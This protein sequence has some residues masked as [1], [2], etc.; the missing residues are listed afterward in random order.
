[1]RRGWPLIAVGAAY[2]IAVLVWI[3]SDR[4]VAEESFDKFSAANTSEEGLSLAMKYLAR[5]GGRPV[6]MLTKPP[7]ELLPRNAVV[8]RL[9][10]G[11]EESSLLTFIRQQHEEEEEEDDAPKGK[12]KKEPAKPPAIPLLTAEEEAF[13]SRGGRFVIVIGGKYPPLDVRNVGEAKPAVKVFPLWPGI[14]TISL[15]ERR[16]L[17]GAAV[18]RR[19]HALYV[20]GEQPAMARALIGSGDLIVLAAPELFE[21]EHVARHLDLLAAL[22]G[23]RRPVYFDETVHG[24]VSD[25]GTLELL[26]GWRLGPMLL[27]L[28]VVTAAVL[29]RGARSVGK[30]ADDFRDTRSDAVDLVVSL[31]ALY[32]KTMTN[33]EAL[34]LYHQALTQTVAAQTGARGEAL[35]KRVAA[36]TGGLQLPDKSEPLGS[37]RF[38][39]FLSKL[40]DAFRRLE[41]AEHR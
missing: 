12:K 27:L 19:M 37:Q 15:P 9:L 6:N 13:I 21:N 36:L 28:L 25:S 18:L 4:R 40:N 5:S 16:T 10:E 31:G 38:D 34:A 17:A 2:V 39:E 7:D 22:A 32:A 26:R 35:Q 41:H 23:E 3:G 20:I 11:G 30:P 14:E 33:S 29:W 24:L 8:F 1:M